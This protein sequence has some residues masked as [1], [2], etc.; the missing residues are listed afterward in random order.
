[1]PISFKIWFVYRLFHR[2]S[3]R[4]YYGATS[5]PTERYR[6]YRFG[7][8]SGPKIGAAIALYGMESFYF[9]IINWF[10]TKDECLSYEKQMIRE[11]DTVWPNGFNL[12]GKGR[13]TLTPNLTDERRQFL[14]ENSNAFWS[15]PANKARH[16]EAMASSEPCRLAKAKKS[17]HL[18][19][20]RTDPIVKEKIR[21]KQIGHA[22]GSSTREKIGA[23]HRGRIHT[24]EA[25]EN[26]AAS[27]RTPEYRLKCSKARK[28]WWERKRQLEHPQGEA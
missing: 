24:K 15:D 26:I 14:K 19:R 8:D 18:K 22:V 9:E 23:A 28:L 5:N 4:V 25:R 17:A 3:G 27:R 6:S 21:S 13:G 16:K 20:M 12:V 10:K 2:E 7:K 11:H 1:M